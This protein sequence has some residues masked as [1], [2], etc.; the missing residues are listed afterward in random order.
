MI[1]APSPFPH[2]GS[3][4]LLIDVEQ[5]VE[6]RRAELA[7]IF[8]LVE[9]EGTATLVN[10]SLPLRTGASGTKVVEL[11]DLIDGTPLSR[12]EMRELAD[13]DSALQGRKLRTPKLKA[14]HE[15]CEALRHRLCFS[16]VLTAELS[17]LTRLQRRQQPS[18]GGYLPA[19]AA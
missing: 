2:V 19:V 15:R 5:P 4:A 10:I 12:E 11:S 13:L 8:S 9:V 14:A 6:L 3:Y 16:Q 17:K 1:K 18:T 7:R